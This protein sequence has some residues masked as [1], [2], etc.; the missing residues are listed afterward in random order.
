MAQKVI[1]LE[2]NEV[3]LRLFGHFQSMRPGSHI[4]RLMSSSK[5]LETLAQDVDES[6]LYPSQTWASLNTGATYDMHQIHWYNDPKPEQYP[7]YWKTLANAGV[8]V[9]AVN[10]LHSSPAASY[11]E[12]NAQYKFLIPDCFAS[13][14]Y[15][16]PSYYKPFQSLN[17]KAVS[18]NSRAASLKAPIQEAMATVLNTPRYGIRMRSMINGAALVTKILLKKANRERLRNL[19]FPLVADIFLHQLKKKDPDLAI[20]F[21]NH[22][23]GNM[24]RYWYALFPNDYQRDIY[25]A[26][27]MA[28]YGT[29]IL[30]AVDMLD[31]YLGVFMKLAEETGRILVLVSSMGQHANLK[32]TPEYRDSHAYDFRLADV[33]R[34]LARL[35]PLGNYSFRVESAM[36]PQY[37]LEFPTAT[38]AAKCAAEIRESMLGVQGLAIEVDENQAVLT[39]SVTQDPQAPTYVIRGQQYTYDQLGFS[40]LDI[41]DHHSGCHCPEGSLIIYNSRTA[42]TAQRSVNYLEYAP[43]LLKHFGVDRPE[44]MMKPS[45]SI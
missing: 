27:W 22:V 14:S 17:L 40:R 9:G 29:E 3:P 35:A 19:Q 15:T 10:T 8:S 32:L 12:D 42:A 30:A 45:F 28:K 25:D 39:V 13:D 23:A 7:L 18:S 26:T 33:K 5:I 41:D 43:A 36:V 44:F 2:I 20:M 37:S 11:A 21:T 31:E 4:D 6:L 24:H 34:L 1:I 38:D 16:K